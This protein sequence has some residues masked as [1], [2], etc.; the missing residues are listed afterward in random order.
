MSD[1]TAVSP[2]RMAMLCLAVTSAL[3]LAGA[4]A[5]LAQVTTGSL[6]GVVEDESGGVLPGATVEAVHEPTKTRYSAVSTA[7]GRFMLL[8]IRVGGPYT[9]TATMSGFKAVEKNGV[10]VRLGEERALSFKMPLESMTESVEVTAEVASIFNPSNT[11]PASNVSQEAIQNLPTVGRGLDDFTRLNPYFA[12]VSIGGTLTNSVSVAGRNNRYN[13]LQIDGAVNNDLFG[14]AASGAPG[15]QAD[16]Q[17]ISLDAIQEIQLLVAPYDVRHGGFSGGGMNAITKSGTNLFAGTVYWFTRNQDFVGNGPDDR[18]FGTFDDD[19][20]GASVGGPIRKDKVF[21]FL[22]ADLQ[23]KKTPNGFAVGGSSGQDFGHQAE[24]ER[25]RGILRDQYGYDPGDFAQE[26]IKTTNNDKVFGRID[27]NLSSRHQ[28]T[29]RH[30]YIDGVNDIYGTSNSST[31]FNFPDAPYQFNSQTNST[32]AQL[33]SSFSAG[34]NELRVTYQRIREFRGHPTDFPQVTVRLPDGANLVAGTEQFSTANALDQDIIELTDDFTFTR[35][36]HTITVGTHNEFFKFANLFIRDNFGT[37]QFANL[38]QLEAGLAQQFDHSFSASSDP[39]QRARFK[40]NQFGLYAGDVW[41]VRPRLTLTLG[42]R[43]DKPFFPDKPARNPVSEENFGVRT[44]VVPNPTMFSPRIGFNYDV[45]GDGK[46]QLRGGVG[47]FSGR[48][49]Y[50]WLSNQYS[51]T[52]LEFTRIG[53]SFNANNRIPF[54]ADPNNQPETVTGASAGSFTNEI[55]VVDPDYDYPRV[56]RG[57]VAYDHDLGIWGLVGTVEFLGAKTLKDIDYENLNRIPGTDTLFDG[58]PRFIRKVGSLSDVVFLT[59]TD[60]GSQWSVSGKLERPFRNGLYASASYI[61]GR[62]KSINDGNSSQALS[63]WRFVYVP[64]DI[65]NPPL[66]FSNFDVRHRI[67]AALSWDVKLFRH[68]GAVLSLFYN[69]QSGRPYSVLFDS[70]VNADGTF[71]NDLLYVPADVS[72]VE[73]INGTPQQLEDFIANDEGLSANRG[74]IVPRNASRSPWTDTLDFRA[75]VNVPWGRRKLEVTFDVLNLLNLIDS[76]KGRFTFLSNQN[77]APIRYGGIDA[78]SG[79]P[80]YNIVAIASPTFR[81]FN[82][83]DLRSR[84]QAQVG[85][86]LRF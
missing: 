20:F 14:L 73:V 7:D 30:N 74:R 79:L 61:Y 59:N 64:G 60:E 35:G 57:N 43:V 6:S 1:K 38:D 40:V 10:T 82:T 65:N 84:W 5:T 25:F 13:N 72:E 70:D 28:L 83:D 85:L 18:E 8:N 45:L 42:L 76:E 11:G 39:G 80:I 68:A 33:N 22:N 77:I 50:V 58:R 21:F 46:K 15:G 67:N 48:T 66:A 55:D 49:P 23:R 52:G 4:D 44:D 78:D 41:R 19:Q 34:F 47:I 63:N 17:P 29:L 71:G 9:V 12:S 81:K 24:A 26:F 27:V 16:A 3:I 37:Y 31:R 2:F 56:L 54:V 75:A 69:G 53:A 86:R 51:N 36:K 32:V 62:A